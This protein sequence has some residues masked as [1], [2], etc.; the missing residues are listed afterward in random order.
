MGTSSHKSFALYE[1]NKKDFS[2][3]FSHLKMNEN[4]A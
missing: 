3:F 2:L 1:A 4:Y